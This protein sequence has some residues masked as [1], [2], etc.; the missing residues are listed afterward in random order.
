LATA[1]SFGHILGAGAAEPPKPIIPAAVVVTV[2]TPETVVNK[3]VRVE[4]GVAVTPVTATPT[5]APTPV[6]STPARSVGLTF[7]AAGQPV[8]PNLAGAVSADGSGPK[9]TGP[10]ALR[11]S[12][13]LNPRV[14][15]SD[16]ARQDLIDN[17]VDNRIVAVIDAI[18]QK[19]TLEVNV[20]RSG[21]GKYVKG[22]R[23]ISNHVVGRGMD[24]RAIDGSSVRSGNTAARLAVDYIL[25]L[26]LEIRPTELGSPWD[27]DDAE[28]FTDRG[29]RD[30][31]HVGFD[32]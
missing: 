11:N 19:Y 22:T 31:L 28:T 20:L 13:L 26:P 16:Q 24:I 2:Q 23:R 10:D 14:T 15:L 25:S 3:T 32:S 12:V 4:A 30:H 8:V 17:R 21:H 7:A 18:A 5:T 6:T 1:V 9:P 29:H 27:T